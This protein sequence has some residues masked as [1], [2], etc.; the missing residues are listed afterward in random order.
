MSVALLCSLGPQRNLGGRAQESQGASALTLTSWPARVDLDL[1]V[2][3]RGL[4]DQMIWSWPSSE[5]AEMVS[6]GRV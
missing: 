4:I 5:R 6:E 3:V 2:S 1:S